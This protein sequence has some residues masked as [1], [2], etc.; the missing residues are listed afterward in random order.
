MNRTALCIKMLELLSSKRIYKVS[1][2]A[3]LLETNPRNVLE[4]KKEL[5]VAGYFIESVSGKYGGYFLNQRNLLS[6]IN[7]TEE[8]RRIFNNSTNHLL[9][10]KEFLYKKEFELIL[11]KIHSAINQKNHYNDLIIINRFS[12]VM[13]EEEIME[14]YKIVKESIEKKLVLEIEYLSQINTTKRY[15]VHPYQLFMFNNSWF[16]IAL[17][18][19]H[20]SIAYFK[21]N[22]ISDYK[23]TS[24]KFSIKENYKIDDY[25][26]EYGMKQN[27]EWMKIEALVFNQY[28]SLIKERIYGRNQV[29]TSIDE[30]TTNLKVEMQNIDSI[31]SFILGFGSNIKIL[32]PQSL[33]DEIVLESK[34]TINH[35]QKEIVGVN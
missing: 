20:D 27:G 10:R 26:D 25:I 21:I 35:Y 28:A 8:E 16:I 19:K 7:F 32:S 18:E 2:L 24:D 34:I 23:L 17:N 5:E 33:I 12:L 30:N 29:V 4:Y 1:E 14:R 3:E 31:K 15:N 6:P 11:S 13:K 9:S 22:R